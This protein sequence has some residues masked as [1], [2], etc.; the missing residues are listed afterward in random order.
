MLQAFSLQ[1]PACLLQLPACLLQL[2]VCLLRM[3]PLPVGVSLPD[4]A[5]HDTMRRRNTEK[6]AHY[7]MQ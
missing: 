1:L 3:L 4:A 5:V 7:E 2:P 6:T